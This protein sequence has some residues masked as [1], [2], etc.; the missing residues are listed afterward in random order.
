M[1]TVIKRNCISYIDFRQSTLQKKKKKKQT[2][3]TLYYDKGII[4]QDGKTILNIY[5]T[6]NR[7]PNS[8]GKNWLNW[9]KYT[10]IFY[11]N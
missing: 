9:G 4:L 11:Y 7:T 1:Y 5:A 10:E 3:K 8:W 2:H 6:N